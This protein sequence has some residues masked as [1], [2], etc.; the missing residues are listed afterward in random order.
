MFRKMKAYGIDLN[1]ELGFTHLKP[2]KKIKGRKH[3][4]KN[5]N[6]MRSI[7]EKGLINVNQKDIEGLYK[8]IESE[9]ESKANQGEFSCQID[10][11][12]IK[13]TKGKPFD[14]DIRMNVAKEI[15]KWGYKISPAG[16]TWIIDWN[17]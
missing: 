13:T 16:D 12:I 7:S 1:K 6:E 5:A 9:I 11:K 17:K 8:L 4:M 3:T 2:T 10:F 14:G 15:E